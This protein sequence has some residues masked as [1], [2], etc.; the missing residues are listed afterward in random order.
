MTQSEKKIHFHSDCPFFAGCENML[1]NLFNDSMLTRQYDLSFSYRYSHQYELGVRQRMPQSID[2]MALKLFDMAP[3]YEYI[4]GLLVK[5]LR[6]LIKIIVNILLIR[7]IR[8]IIIFYNMII[9]YRL[10]SR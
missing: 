1:V 5:P 10:F 2:R 3:I 6:I 4:N 7:Y 9:L 8:Y